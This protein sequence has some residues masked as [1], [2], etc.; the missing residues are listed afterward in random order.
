MF[1]LGTVDISGNNFTT[2]AGTGGCY[3]VEVTGN[4]MR[5]TGTYMLP[6]FDSVH[7]F[8]LYDLAARST[9]PTFY[10]RVSKIFSRYTGLPSIYINL[11]Y[12][13]RMRLLHSLES[14]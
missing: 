11:P 6:D 5:E 8:H 3:R 2:E 7:N 1:G 10:G 13:T 12:E 9:Y 14:I 4:T